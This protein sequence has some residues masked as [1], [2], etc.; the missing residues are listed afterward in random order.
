[1]RADFDAK[2]EAVRAAKSRVKEASER[3]G[4]QNDRLKADLKSLQLEC[5]SLKRTVG[6][7]NER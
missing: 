5:E 4:E 7:M 6:E 3:H 1:M 2:M